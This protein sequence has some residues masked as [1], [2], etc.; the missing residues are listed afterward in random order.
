MKIIFLNAWRG[1]LKEKITSYLAKEI[2]DT[3]IFCI[4]E[5]DGQMGLVVEEVM[6]GYQISSINKNIVEDENLSITNF[7]KN[8][9][10]LVKSESIIENRSDLGLGL[11][12]QIKT[13]NGLI[14]LG[15]I[16]GL[17]RPGP[18]LDTAERIEQSE[19]IISFFETLEGR[20]IIGG[21][22][23]LLPDQKS[24]TMFEENGYIDL[25]KKYKIE[26][27]RNK[28]AWK[29]YPESVLYHSDYLFVSPEVKIKSFEV[30][31]IEV[32]DHLPL[33]LE[34]ED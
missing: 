32:S 28:H 6:N 24:I 30:P 7:F 14:N 25:I 2:E 34:I 33:V 19:Q 22:F 12:S 21:D 11:F 4:Q 18:K 15:N 16:H 5:S 3:D 13:K 17:P 9:I 20:K 27:T 8:E 10:E 31:E 23:N 29:L 26:T 1:E